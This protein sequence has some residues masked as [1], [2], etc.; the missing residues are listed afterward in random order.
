MR[1][2]IVLALACARD[3]AGDSAGAATG[4]DVRWTAEPSPVQAG[5]P[6]L[7]TLRVLDGAGAPVEDLARTHARMVHTVFLSPD[8]HGFLHLH[9][10]DSVPVDADDLRAARF[11]FPVTFD[12][13]GAWRVAFDFG[14]RGAYHQVLDTV[15]V[16]GAPAVAAPDA[17]PAD[18]AEAGG[19]VGEIAFAR[20]PVAGVP[21]SWTVRLSEES[22]GA[23]T[24]VVPWL[25]SD[26]HA[27]LA[28]ADLG[29]VAHTHAWFPGMEAMAPGHPMPHLYDGPDLPFQAVFPT[30]GPWVVWT[31]FARAPAPDA[32]YTLRF[33]VEVGSP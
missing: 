5:T 29:A 1:A 8:L 21:A 3:G 9:Q 26:G 13:A 22:G 25:E 20:P 12:A 19:V 6:T 32:P 33:V 7:F 23:V 11:S 2:V 15:P 18:R 10:E 28:P 4:Y 16:E 24:D 14:H 27:V 31:Q 17:G 30:P